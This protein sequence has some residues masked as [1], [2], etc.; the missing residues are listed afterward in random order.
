MQNGAALSTAGDLTNSAS[1]ADLTVS[2]GASLTAGGTLANTGYDASV[3]IN[4]AT[5]TAQALDNTAEI[6]VWNNAVLG[7]AGNLTNSGTMNGTAGGLLTKSGAALDQG[8]MNVSG[9]ADILGSLTV[10]GSGTLTLAGG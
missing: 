7:V 10:T 1:Y 9:A 3:N 2:N 5:V 4:D 8:V 6:R